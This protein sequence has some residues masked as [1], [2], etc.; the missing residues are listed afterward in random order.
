MIVHDMPVH[1]PIVARSMTYVLSERWETDDEIKEKAM[2]VSFVI[3][4]PIS[5]HMLNI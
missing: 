4:M 1:E 2:D 3:I 5:T